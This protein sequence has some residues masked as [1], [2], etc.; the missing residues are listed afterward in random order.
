MPQQNE[1]RQDI[2][3]EGTNAPAKYT[4]EVQPTKA[5]RNS[6]CL[7]EQ[8]TAYQGPSTHQ[9]ESSMRDTGKESSEA[10]RVS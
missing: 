10:E 1:G 2:H 3:V 7:V 4:H 5:Y 8:H 6:A 9:P